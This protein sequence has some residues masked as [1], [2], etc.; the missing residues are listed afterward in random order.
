MPS[1]K[2]FLKQSNSITGDLI[3]LGKI[4]HSNFPNKVLNSKGL[5]RFGPATER[6]TSTATKNRPYP[7][8]Y[9]NFTKEQYYNFRMVNG[10]LIQ[11]LY[12]FQN[13]Q[14]ITHVLAFSPSPDL[15]SFQ[16]DPEYYQSGE[17]FDDVN[18]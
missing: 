8:I 18:T 13:K 17:I 12:R 15:E 16:N 3:T 7:K 14:L 4:S 10:A 6:S 11:M 1:A 2:Q 9:V 5:R